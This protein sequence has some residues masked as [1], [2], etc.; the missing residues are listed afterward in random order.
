MIV[1]YF[2][3]CIIRSQRFIQLGNQIVE[4]FPSEI[5]DMYYQ[6]YRTVNKHKIN[7]SGALFDHFE[8]TKKI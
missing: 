2:F 7:P 5:Q 1:I 4:L 6:P 3:L 8:Y